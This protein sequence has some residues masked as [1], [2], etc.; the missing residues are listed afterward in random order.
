MAKK[1]YLCNAYLTG[2]NSPAL[3][4]SSAGNWKRETSQTLRPKSFNV[5]NASFLFFSIIYISY[6]LQTYLLQSDSFP[7]LLIARYNIICQQWADFLSR[8]ASRPPLL[9][10][11]SFTLVKRLQGFSRSKPELFDKAE[12]PSITTLIGLAFPAPLKN[13]FDWFSLVHLNPQVLPLKLSTRQSMMLLVK[14]LRGAHRNWIS[15]AELNCRPRCNKVQT[16]RMPAN[17]LRCWDFGFGTHGRTLFRNQY[18]IWRYP[19]SLQGI[20]QVLS[21]DWKCPLLSPFLP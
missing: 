3:V 8:Q 6:F 15:N 12:H 20:D 13:N 14:P 7:F 19:V 17:P 5:I 18:S 21:W 10:C 11:G 4:L 1:A 16:H 2:R 9:D